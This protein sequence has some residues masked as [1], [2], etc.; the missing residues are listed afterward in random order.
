[1][2]RIITFAFAFSAIGIT[3]AQ[4]APQR[5]ATAGQH[6]LEVNA[7]WASMRPSLFEGPDDVRFHSDAERIAEHLHRVQRHLS[8]HTPAG[9]GPE[10]R[11]HRLA[12]LGALEAY[13]DGG[14]F[15]INDVVPGR[16]PVFIDDNGTA[17]AVGHLMIVSGHADIADHV[18]RAMNLA[19]IRD[20]ALPEVAQWATD[21]GFT[22]NE[23]AWIQPTYQHMR[24]RGPEVLATQRLSDGEL[25]LV[26]GP[27][28]ARSTQK[29][30]LVRRTRTGDKV[31]ARLPM[32]SSIQLVEYDGRVFVGGVPPV[33]G[34]SPEIFEWSGAKL[35][36]HDPFP[37]PLGVAALYVA[38]GKLRA[39]SYPDSTGRTY[40]RICTEAGKWMIADPIATPMEPD[41]TLPH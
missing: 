28:D 8:T 36:K 37:G 6:M 4:L 34:P 26:I 21:H 31:L 1:M 5:P 11:A 35:V 2:L 17:C 14:R 19:Y 15:P 32:L 23:L 41:R 29:L 16:A 38:D 18:H 24:M 22:T 7:Q 9:I 39:H 12:L 40:E 20:I 10:A 25:I 30:Q 13:A 3:T 27:A 33:N